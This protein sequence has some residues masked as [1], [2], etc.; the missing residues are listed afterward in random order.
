MQEIIQYCNK[1]HSV[2]R[3]RC[4]RGE[5][6]HSFLFHSQTDKVSPITF[7]ES[8][9]FKTVHVVVFHSPSSV[10]VLAVSRAHAVEVSHSYATCIFSVVYT[11]SPV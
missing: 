6:K 9:Q 11:N 7:K 5:T 8:I 3:I 2:A 1:E 4:M 10:N